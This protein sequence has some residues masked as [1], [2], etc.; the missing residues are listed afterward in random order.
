MN[1]TVR[2]IF[3]EKLLKSEICEPCVLFMAPNVLKR[4]EKSNSAATVHALCQ[5]KK[6]KGKR[7]ENADVAKIISIQ[8]GT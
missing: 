4:V 1:S 6:K 8:T 5:K 3:N 7:R 2:L